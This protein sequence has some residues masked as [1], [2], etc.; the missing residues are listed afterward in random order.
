MKTY[1]GADVYLV[2][3]LLLDLGSSWRW[4]PSSTLLPLY[5]RKRSSGTHWIGGCVEPRTRI[6]DV[7]RR[8]FL[9]P[10]ELKLRPLGRSA[11]S[12]SL[13]RLRYPGSQL[14]FSIQ[15]NRNDAARDYSNAVS[16]QSTANAACILLRKNEEV[17]GSSS[18]AVGVGCTSQRANSRKSVDICY[19]RQLQ[20]DL[21]W[22]DAG[23]KF[24]CFNL[25]H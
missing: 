2:D 6:D 22:T 9:P 1:G 15:G 18:L 3:P 8:K 16:R 4:V 21:L 5:P 19:S 12:Q 25:L 7:G 13:Y 17:K 11:H 23:S 14:S 20:D 10:S 24:T